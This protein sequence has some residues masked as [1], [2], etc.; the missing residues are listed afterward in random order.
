MNQL[1][2][3]KKMMLL[4]NFKQTNC[5]KCYLLFCDKIVKMM[6]EKDAEP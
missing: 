6:K 3:D 4:T 5:L 2:T 1:D